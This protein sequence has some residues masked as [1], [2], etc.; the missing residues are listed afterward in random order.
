MKPSG[1]YHRLLSVEDYQTLFLLR[2]SLPDSLVSD[3]RAMDCKWK[4]HDWDGPSFTKEV[5][6]AIYEVPDGFRATV[7]DTDEALQR[8]NSRFSWEHLSRDGL[9]ADMVDRM[10]LTESFYLQHLGA[11]VLSLS[12]W[13]ASLREERNTRALELAA[14]AAEQSATAAKESARQAHESGLDAA[15]AQK[16]TIWVAALGVAATVFASW[17]SA[18]LSRPDVGSAPVPAASS[19]PRLPMDGGDE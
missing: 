2:R 10:E 1:T 15:R 19:Q 13:G 7:K 9:I 5:T 14:K 11:E 3:L 17:L 4:R 6:R 18:Y 12:A 16:L 8:T